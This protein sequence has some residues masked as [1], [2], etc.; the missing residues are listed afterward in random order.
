M[1]ELII[2][3]VLAMSLQSLP[4]LGEDMKRRIGEVLGRATRT[5][6]VGE[7]PD[8]G[9]SLRGARGPLTCGCPA[10][11]RDNLGT[12]VWGNQVYTDDSNICLAAIHDGRVS[13]SGGRVTV[14]AAP[15]QA[16][17][18]SATRNGITSWDYQ[19]FEGSIRFTPPGA[20]YKERPGSETP[21]DR[22]LAPAGPGGTPPPAPSRRIERAKPVEDE[23]AVRRSRPYKASP[24]GHD[25]PA[26]RRAPM[27]T[28]D[29]PEIGRPLRGTTAPLT[30]G[31]PA[32]DREMLGTSVWGSGVYT[33]DSN[34]CLAAIHDGRVSLSGGTVTVWSTRGRRIY[35]SATRN[36]ITSW[37]YQ[38][39]DG[40]FQ[41]SPPP[42]RAR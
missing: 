40:S 21:E 14:W 9:A 19:D 23:T 36:G 32:V 41:F 16:R 1:F 29:C 24:V 26:A 11:D 8:T 6:S 15:G 25:F 17:Y 38:D 13:T 27:A 28:S 12:S 34:I 7:C 4:P 30:C 22:R 37:A 33:D 18:S 31:C 20:R 5:G 39:F 35:N 10:V 2:T 3:G 42:H